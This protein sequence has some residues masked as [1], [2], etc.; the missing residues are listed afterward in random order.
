MTVERWGGTIGADDRPG[1]G[2]RFWFRLPRALEESAVTE[3]VPASGEQPATAPVSPGPPSELIGP[4]EKVL[5][6]L[7]ADD[8][9]TIRELAV[10]LLRSRGHSVTAAAD[11]RT[12]L[13]AMNRVKP[14]V[15]LLDQEMP[16][17]NG[18][19]AA[20]AIR[21]KETKSRGKR[22]MIIGLSGSALAEDQ[23]RAL[24]AGMDA[25]LAKPFDRGALFQI[26][27]SPARTPF[28]ASSEEIAPPA[29][30]EANLRAHLQRVTEGS[31]KLLRSLVSSFLADA[32]G[33]LSA[34]ERAVARKDAEKLA[35]RAHA[36]KGAIAIFNAQ[37]SVSAARN[38]EAM[39]R[40]CRLQGAGEE[41]RALK[42]DLAHLERELRALLPR[43][44]GNRS[45]V[46]KRTHRGRR[47]RR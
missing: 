44:P 40:T 39:G 25:F 28:S 34:I 42:D 32:P 11:G 7:V 31:E 3:E 30:R 33:K 15:V 5:S 13:R 27:E 46:S 6:I 10:A 47:G 26:V 29:E 12:A 19:E 35:S 36:L 22:A 45:L 41:L 16:H 24:D 37:R 23:R 38:L 4:P 1:G 17:M 18:M 20:R 9:E 8:N 43:T 14:D 21:E 2:S